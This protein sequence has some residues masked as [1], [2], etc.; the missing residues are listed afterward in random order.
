MCLVPPNSPVSS[1]ASSTLAL[2]RAA[3]CSLLALLAPLLPV[4]AHAQSVPYAPLGLAA[5]PLDGQAALSWGD[6][7]DSTITG[8]SVRYATSLPVGGTWTDISG[9]GATT[10]SHTVAGLSNGTRYYFQ[11]R[12][13][14]AFGDSA[15]STATTQLA[16]SPAT[17]VTIS[18]ANLRARLETLT[19]KAAGEAITQLDMAALDPSLRLNNRGISVLTGLEWAINVDELQLY[20]NQITDLTPL[21]GLTSLRKLW[22]SNNRITDI[23][24]LSGLA[25]LTKLHLDGN[26]ISD[27]GPLSGLASLADLD[28]DGNRISD[29]TPLASLTSLT[30]LEL[31]QNRVSDLTPLSSLTALREVWLTGNQLSDITPLAS[32]TLRALYLGSTGTLDVAP[33]AVITSLE[34]LSLD[35]NRVF[36]V[37]PLGGLTRLRLL[38]LRNTGTSDLAPLATL[39][40][41]F[42]LKLQHN[43]ISDVTPL[44]GLS[45]LGYLELQ[46]NR[47]SDVTPLGGLTSLTWLRLEHNR[48]SDVTPLAGITSLWLLDLHDN[49]IADVDALGGI[50]SLARLYLHNNAISNV[51]ALAANRGIGVGITGGDQVNLRGNPLSK[52]SIYVHIPTMRRRGAR[53]FFD[54]PPNASPEAVRKLEDAVLAVGGK[55]A[56]ELPD[57]FRDQDNETLTLSAMSSRPAVAPA[58]MVG[59]TLTVRALAEGQARITVRAEDA[60]G[61]SASLSFQVTVGN[62]VSFVGSGG[63]AAVASAAEGDSASL[64]VTMA[65]PRNEDVSFAYSFGPDADP[66]TADADAADYG[67]EGGTVTIAAGETEAT[68]LVPILDDDDIEPARESFA[69]TLT[70]SDAVGLGVATATVHIAEGVCDRTWQVADALRGGWSCEAVTATELAHQRTVRLADVGLVE[71]Q[72]L[73]FLGLTGLRTLILDGNGLSA[74]PE[75]LLAGSPNLRVLRL[76]GNSFETLPAVG[77]AG[78]LV[79]L[80]LGDNGL[81]ELPAQPFAGLPAL[82]YL[83]LDGNQIEALPPDLLSDAGGM[84]ILELQ[85]NALHALPEGIFAG[86]SKLT[87]LQ[88]QGNPGAPFPLT[89]ELVRA[90]AEDEDAGWAEVQLRMSHA[91]PFAVIAGISAP[92][93]TLSADTATIA[94]GDTVGGQ[95]SVV[96]SVAGNEAGD[97]VTIA[98][99]AVGSLPRTTCGDDFDEYRCFRGFELKAGNDLTLFEPPS[100]A[101]TRTLRMR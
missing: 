61:A 49:A 92:E 16:T 65:R 54:A 36:D 24:P 25:S 68:I 35:N 31:A 64:A 93:A 55:L 100:S 73:D 57:A 91:A 17:G 96:R 76:R 74:L 63:I 75:G 81:L 47:I 48:I 87:S 12:A 88:L 15:P 82:G 98:V 9:S 86:A 11:I 23:T 95:V 43:R 1:Q 3:L 83:Y 53:I 80:D 45:S 94:A 67:G 70:S 21:G 28:L 56:V 5:K 85:N 39:A 66:A 79:E 10:T 34:F 13:A 62:P 33:L 20:V 41:L 27:L 78:A 97:A 84:R 8:Y 4:A 101:Q 58:R 69:V 60:L 99:T 90:E 29:L 19:G 42:Y 14:N 44:A 71:L 72:P 89:V 2:L 40:S 77:N 32:L 52:E 50:T 18:D 7:S 37:S 6:P 51:A 38:S 59:Y 22:L 46:H 30:E 26:R